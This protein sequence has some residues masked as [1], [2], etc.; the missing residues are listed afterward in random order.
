MKA[1]ID[2]GCSLVKAAWEVDGEVKYASTDDTNLFLENII[3]LMRK[4]GI[5]KVN[6]IG[7]LSW[8]AQVLYGEADFE[9]ILAVPP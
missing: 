2:L 4:D 7:L 8:G 9:L 6:S 3:D 1:G 5:K